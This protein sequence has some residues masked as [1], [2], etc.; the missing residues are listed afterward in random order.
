MNILYVVPYAPNRI[1]VR[2]YQMIRAL[3]Q[4][5]HQVTLF[6]LWAGE[7]ERRDIENLSRECYEVNALQ[8]QRWRS[9]W[10][11][12]LVLPE[13]IPF[14]AV[15]SWHPR[16]AAE[17]NS[18][19]A[20]KSSYHYDMIHVE[21]LRGVR[22]G[23]YIKSRNPKIP[24]VWD[25]VDCISYLFSQ[26]SGRSRSWFGRFITNLDLQRTRS[27]EANLPGYFDHVFVTSP[28]DQQALLSLSTP[29]ALRTPISVIPNGVDLKYFTPGDPGDRD[30]ASVVFSGK[31]SYHANITMAMHLAEEVMPRVW[32]KLPATQLV[33]VGK[34][35]PQSVT[36]LA[37]NPAITVTGTVEDIRP[38]LRKATVAAVPLVYGAGLQN[39][40]L[41]AM[42][43]GTPVVA[44]SQAISALKVEAGR[45][46]L[47]AQGAEELAGNI[48]TVVSDRGIQNALGQ[49]GRKF[50]EENHQWLAIAGLVEEKYNEVIQTQGGKN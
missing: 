8:L 19:L 50:V 7:G 36:S 46:L 42:A 34:D 33:I 5:G 17:M 12:L 28:I 26:A 4:R 27:Y 45:D 29:G 47:V 15:Y 25:S 48:I 16:L 43:C 24:V 44:T 41:E 49:A 38:Y 35:P 39:K 11:C 10:N 2:P 6:S 20:S 3:E 9:I 32:E 40:V 21:H 23:L 31:M 22:Y 18:R 13:K 37:K 14:Q 30:S 1:R